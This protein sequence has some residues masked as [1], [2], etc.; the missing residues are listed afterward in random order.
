MN[1]IEKFEKIKALYERTPYSGEKENARKLMER[2]EKELNENNIFITS[3]DKYIKDVIFDGHILCIYEE[4]ILYELKIKELL[5]PENDC[6]KA[7]YKC[8]IFKGGKLI[9]EDAQLELWLF[10]E[11]SIECDDSTLSLWESPIEELPYEVNHYFRNFAM[12]KWNS[13]VQDNDFNRLTS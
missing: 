12:K 13:F 7:G 9:I 5:K 8:D 1:K 3:D 6:M 11:Y 10:N 2:L 4:E